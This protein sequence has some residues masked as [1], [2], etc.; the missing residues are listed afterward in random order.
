MTSIPKGGPSRG[1]YIHAFTPHFSAI[2][3]FTPFL[4]GASFTPLSPQSRP[5]AHFFPKLRLHAPKKGQS[6]LHA[7]IFGQLRHHARFFVITPSR[8][9]LLN[10]A[11][12]PIFFLNHAFTPKK[13]ANH[14]FTP[15]PGGA[16]LKMIENLK[17]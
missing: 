1:G 10:H 5:H 3:A 14:A 17:I 8:L 7:V 11:F 6:R 12:T 2:H 4:G 13:K 15:S 16:S 9:C